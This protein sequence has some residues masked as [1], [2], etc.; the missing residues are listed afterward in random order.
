[1]LILDKKKD[2]H[3]K[4]TLAA[5]LELKEGVPARL[6]EPYS[7]LG[8]VYLSGQRCGYVWWASDSWGP[9]GLHPWECF[10]WLNMAEQL[11]GRLLCCTPASWFSAF[12][13]ACI[14]L[15][16]W[17]FFA[18]LCASSEG[19]FKSFRV[20][21]HNGLDIV[22]I[23]V[24]MDVEDLEF[25]RRLALETDSLTFTLSSS[26]PHCFLMRLIFILCFSLIG[27]YRLQ[28]LP[29]IFRHNNV[30]CFWCN[31]LFLF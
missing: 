12:M 8:F 23:L 2:L 7:A 11:L 10:A 25:D 15:H 19:C 1:M 3:S 14:C 6:N 18:G 13:H 26:R 9:W 20:C 4:F 27:Y 28:I 22:F 24:L 5:V 16:G 29:S 31:I 17:D 21:S 30:P